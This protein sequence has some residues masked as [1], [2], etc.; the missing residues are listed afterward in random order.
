[1]AIAHGKGDLTGWQYC[2]ADDLDRLNAELLT[3][4]V[5][6]RLARRTGGLGCAELVR[7]LGVVPHPLLCDVL[8][9][10]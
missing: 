9:T 7:L 6:L 4:L 5:L 3:L 2:S 8:A 1:M 10:R